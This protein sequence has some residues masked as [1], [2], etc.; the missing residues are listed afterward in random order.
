[1]TDDGLRT[2]HEERFT[3]F[4]REDAKDA[5]D[6]SVAIDAIDATD[7]TDAPGV[8]LASALGGVNLLC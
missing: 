3:L 5:S 2:L 6:A 1:M 7:A 8:T 4:G